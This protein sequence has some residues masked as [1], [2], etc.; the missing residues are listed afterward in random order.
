[1]V[2]GG[3]AKETVNQGVSKGE[4][5]EIRLSGY[6]APNDERVENRHLE[7]VVNHT[8]VPAVMVGQLNGVV[9]LHVVRRVAEP[10][11][12]VVVAS[13]LRSWL[14][15]SWSSTNSAANHDSVG[16]FVAGGEEKCAVL[17]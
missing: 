14:L 3:S 9:P 11:V 8:H 4:V 13:N 1:M 2:S 10:H 16:R 12:L 15:H 17:V 7:H 5:G 6:T